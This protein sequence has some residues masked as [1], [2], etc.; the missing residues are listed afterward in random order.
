MKK[1]DIIYEDDKMI[2]INKPPKLPTIAKV[3]GDEHN[4][5]SMVRV[6]VKRKNKNNKIFIVHRLDK[7]TSGIVLFAKDEELKNYLQDNWNEC[8]ILR[9]YIALVKNNLKKKSDKLINYLKENKNGEVFI[10]NN[11]K[12]KLAITNYEV[13]KENRKYAL[14]RVWIETGK[15]HQ[16]RAQLSNISLPIVG[17]KLY[18]SKDNPINRLG[19]HHHKLI[20]K[21]HNQEYE[22]TS[23]IPKEFE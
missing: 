15:K 10:S 13:I 14:L 8:T 16:I 17:D 5:Y 20:I 18:N 23:P 11:P 4:L 9:E 3:K 22:F 6:Y 2:A 19:L 12:D 7:D 1:L 21:I